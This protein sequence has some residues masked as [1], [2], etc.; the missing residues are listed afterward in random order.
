MIMLAMITEC[1]TPQSSHRDTFFSIYLV[2]IIINVSNLF[3]SSTNLT[4]LA[5]A[6]K[7]LAALSNT[8]QDGNNLLDAA[9]ALAGATSK[10]LDASHPDNIEVQYLS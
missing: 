9:R 5:K 2:Y 1:W 3:F 8:Q 4:E 7:M 10:L 6:V